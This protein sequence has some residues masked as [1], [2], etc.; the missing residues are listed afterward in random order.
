[1]LLLISFCRCY[2]CDDDI[3]VDDSEPYRNIR[4]CLTVLQ[5]GVPPPSQKETD[6]SMT[7]FI[8]S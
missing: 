7:S 3:F 6:A 1:M 2:E 4:D 8:D 5:G